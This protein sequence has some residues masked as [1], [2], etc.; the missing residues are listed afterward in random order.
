M[1]ICFLTSVHHRRD[2]RIFLK[3]I[4]S[5]LNAGFDVSAIV[6]DGK[7]DEL[8]MGYKI[9]DVG[10]SQTRINRIFKASKKI[11]NKALEVN[12]EIYHFHDP[13][14]IPVGLKLKKASKK[15][16]Y[17]IHEDVPRDIMSKEWLP[18]IFRK[19]IA[20]WF[21]K[22]ENRSVKKFDYIITATPFINQRF[23]NLNKHSVTINNFPKLDELVTKDSTEKNERAVCYIGEITKIRGADEFVGA[24]EFVD[25][26]LLLAGN[27]ETEEYKNKL[28]QIPGWNKVKEFGFVNREAAREILSQSS[29]GLVI[30]HPEP[31]H[32]NAQPNKI[33]EYMS[34]G[35]PVIGSNFP[36]WKEIIEGNNCG[37]CIDS[38]KPKDIAAVIQKI[39]DSPNAALKMGENGRK[40]VELYYNWEHEEKKIIDI[41]KLLE[42]L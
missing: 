13:E 21:E 40:A 1:Q 26:R 24:M 12:A 2:T 4:P 36:L 9:Y 14:L 25:G 22:Y 42:N 34:A 20:A 37:I 15:V 27:Y 39:F 19:P 18:W 16:I 10:N 11:L 35:I 41:Y 5:L 32:I 30:F 29:A 17:D 28:T 31:N 33:F 3:E 6:A 23:Q 7:G 38:L 8:F